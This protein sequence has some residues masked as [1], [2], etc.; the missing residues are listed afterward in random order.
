MLAVT[1]ADSFHS[2]DGGSMFLWNISSNKSHMASHPPPWKSQILHVRIWVSIQFQ[3]STE[4]PG[5]ELDSQ[6]LNPSA[7]RNRLLHAQRSVPLSLPSRAYYRFLSRGVSSQQ[8]EAGHS[9]PSNMFLWCGAYVHER[10]LYECST[11]VME[12]E[13]PKHFI[14]Q[15]QRP[16][17]SI[18]SLY[19]NA[20]LPKVKLGNFGVSLCTNFK[21]VTKGVLLWTISFEKLHLWFIWKIRKYSY[22][23]EIQRF[24]CWLLQCQMSLSQ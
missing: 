7:G 21:N 22:V 17:L 24:S 9:L 20:L 4:V 13:D 5:S 8:C 10:I 3:S 1:T 19:S 15:L 11:P 6:G 23:A 14:P 12:I 18:I 16:F 2:D